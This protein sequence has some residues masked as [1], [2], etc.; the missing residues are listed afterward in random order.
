MKL[1][2]VPLAPNPVR[3]MLYIAER[4]ALGLEMNISQEVVN[5]LKGKHKE[6][7]HLARNPFGSLPVL[8]CDDGS[9]IIESR[10]IIDYL[11]DIFP[12][13]RLFSQDP[14]RRAQQRD[15]ERICEVRI[16][17]Y[18][19]EWVHVVK[20]PL[21]WPPNPAR[22][23]ELE[24]R[25]APGF[26]YVDQT[27]SDGRPFLCGDAVS[28]ADCS[29]QGFLQFARFTGHDCLE[30]YAHIARWDEA[31]RRREEIAHILTL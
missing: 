18:L 27:L 28:V 20:S 21:G 16:G 12:D 30:A 25:M 15:M 7:E 26:D 6:A 24:Q 1:Y 3:V 14:I 22:A 13:H 9:Y 4:Q 5:T 19:A 29:L 2:M 17:N 8:A 31:Y 10:V 23:Q 11:E